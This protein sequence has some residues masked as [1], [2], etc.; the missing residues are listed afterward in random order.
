MDKELDAIARGIHEA[1]SYVPWRD[2]HK[3]R[4]KFCILTARTILSAVRCGQTLTDAA[5]RLIVWWQVDN[6]TKGRR[7]RA[8]APPWVCDEMDKL[9]KSGLSGLARYRNTEKTK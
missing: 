2:A 6:K 7:G 8:F 4:R 1:S 9:T 5:D 3:E